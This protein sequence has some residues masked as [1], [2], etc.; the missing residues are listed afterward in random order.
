MRDTTLSLDRRAEGGSAP[1]PRG[2]ARDILRAV[3]LVCLW[4]ASAGAQNYYIQY[5]VRLDGVLTQPLT[6]V[7]DGGAGDNIGAPTNV[8]VA[9]GPLTNGIITITGEISGI[10]IPPAEINGHYGRR[11]TVTNV[12]VSVPPGSA[13]PAHNAE[14]VACYGFL[15]GP[16]KPA[17]TVH[18][19]NGTLTNLAP[20]PNDID[21]AALFWQP[22]ANACAPPGPGDLVGQAVLVPRP[23]PANATMG[24]FWSPQ[25]SSLAG[26]YRFVVNRDGDA[27]LL[28]N[29]AEHESV[30][31]D[32]PSVPVA[33]PWGTALLVAILMMVG[34]L[35]SRKPSRWASGS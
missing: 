13:L 4:T 16:V 9:F 10:Q 2:H 1:R 8:G 20:Q 34:W 11:L 14:L 29:S 15:G 30:Q 7:P 22:T 25:V 24:P 3:V 21:L 28:P 31:Q 35:V 5:S 27:I 33:G 12:T 6:V 18:R 32:S 17:V 23:V 26:Y 19:I